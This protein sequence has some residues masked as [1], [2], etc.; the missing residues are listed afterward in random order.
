MIWLTFLKGDIMK[1][2][3]FWIVGTAV[4]CLCVGVVFAKIQPHKGA[5]SHIGTQWEYGWYSSSIA[6]TRGHQFCWVTPTGSIIE[7]KEKDV[8]EKEGFRTKDGN[9]LADWFN[10]LGKQGWEL[11]CVD[12]QSSKTASEKHYWFKRRR[13][14]RRYDITL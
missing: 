4:I 13:Q 5:Q 7:K 2:G 14:Q 9:L 10:F 3:L 8:W 6:G 11:I 1:K 12:T